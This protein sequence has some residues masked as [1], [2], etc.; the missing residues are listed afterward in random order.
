[1]RFLC[2][3]LAVAFLVSCSGDK[4]KAQSVRKYCVLTTM[5]YRSA[6]QIR[7]IH[8]RG[9]AL[10]KQRTP[11][12]ADEPNRRVI[13]AATTVVTT[14][15]VAAKQAENPAVARDGSPSR[16]VSI[17]MDGLVAACRN[18]PVDVK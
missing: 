14:T 2:L 8:T 12:K 4:P 10:F 5:P 11:Y 1:M 3:L 9:L 13:N 18:L 15:E 16:V 6:A 17:A 7:A